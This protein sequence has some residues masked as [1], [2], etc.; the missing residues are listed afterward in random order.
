MLRFVLF[1]TASLVGASWAPTETI[2]AEYYG[3]LDLAP[4]ACVDTGRSSVVNRVCYDKSRLFM[5]VQQRLTYYAYCKTPA[6]TF[7]DFL[8][9]QSMGKYYNDNIKGEGPGGRFDCGT[10]RVV[11]Y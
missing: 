2:E 11:A 5:V 7:G 4:F 10:H 8:A 6:D 9:A 1:I 3:K